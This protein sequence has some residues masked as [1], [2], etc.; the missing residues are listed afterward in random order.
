MKQWETLAW[1]ELVSTEQTHAAHFY[2]IN[3]MLVVY[4]F[5]IFKLNIL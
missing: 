2:I 1:F 3:D 5:K 4:K